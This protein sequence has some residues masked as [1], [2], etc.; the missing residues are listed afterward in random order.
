MICLDSAQSASCR[1][2]LGLNGV[3]G[4]KVFLWQLVNIMSTYMSNCTFEPFNDN[5]RINGT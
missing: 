4:I 5:Y 3:T 2:S 1:F